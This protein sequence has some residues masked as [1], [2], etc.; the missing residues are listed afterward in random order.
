MGNRRNGRRL[1]PGVL[2]T[3]YTLLGYG[4]GVFTD[5]AAIGDGEVISGGG[6]VITPE[7]IGDGGGLPTPNLP[8]P[9]DPQVGK[10]YWQRIDTPAAQADITYQ[11][12]DDWPVT[13]LNAFFLL[14]TSAVAGNRTGQVAVVDSN[15]QPLMIHY[16]NISQAAG[17]RGYW[18]YGNNFPSAAGTI[19]TLSI[20]G[21]IYG[22]R[23]NFFP[24]VILYPYQT[25][26]ST[27]NWNAIGLKA[28][29]Q[30]TDGV[31]LLRHEK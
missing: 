14:T 20:G 15:E 11:H 4:R 25:F 22:L 17:I 30:I 9:A 27:F 3:R 1:A 21:V 13:I 29:D 12:L 23:Q 7:Q 31:L 19:H 16:T 26:R 24:E 8:P 6:E 2:D 5:A 28:G 18:Q 10:Y